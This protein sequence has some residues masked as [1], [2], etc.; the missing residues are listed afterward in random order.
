MDNKINLE[1]HGLYDIALTVGCF[2][3]LHAGHINLLRKM[4]DMAANVIVLIHNNKSIFENKGKF[5]VQ[6]LEDRE[7][8]V[9]DS[10]L[11]N[12]TG[13]VGNADPSYELEKVIRAYLMK[14]KRIVYVRGDDWKE[15]PGK[16]IVEKYKIPIIYVHYT[17]GVSS[18]MLR[19][20]LNASV[21][22]M[23][24]PEIPDRKSFIKRLF[25][26]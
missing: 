16:A 8:N 21:G 3:M 7:S 23:V 17:K 20:Q 24:V 4:K 15:F 11:A 18:T 5:P 1:Q 14:K 12:G 26:F 25:N 22:Y 13:I 2:D 10:D 19:D 6:N 9:M